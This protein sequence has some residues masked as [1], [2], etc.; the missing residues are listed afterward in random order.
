M[1]SSIDTS[2]LNLDE[3][4]KLPIYEMPPTYHLGGYGSGCFLDAPGFPSYMVQPIYNRHGNTPN[5][6]PNHVLDVMGHLYIVDPI[7]EDTKWE[8]HYAAYR[9]LLHRI[10]SPLPMEHE[11]VQLWIAA[12][13]R[14]FHQCYRDVERPEYGN[15]GTLIYPTPDYTLEH[16]RQLCL[17]PGTPEAEAS[18]IQEAIDA[19]LAR[20]KALNEA[21]ELRAQRIAIP[22]NHRAVLSI[23]EFYPGHAPHLEWI[24]NPP[25]TEGQVGWWETSAERPTPE[26]CVPRNSLVRSGIWN[27]PK[28]PGHHCHFCGHTNPVA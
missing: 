18:K 25:K 3:I 1:H 27:H 5:N 16:P 2:T 6:A 28:E 14:H 21:E 17:T 24:A 19:E 4:R 11:R 10:W 8:D 15:P 22:E 12:T 9:A 23:Q 26:T 20:V 7:S 13:Y